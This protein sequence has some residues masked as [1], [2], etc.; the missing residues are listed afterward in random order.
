MTEYEK[1]KAWRES[2]GLTQEK[3]GELSGWSQSAIYWMEC[4]LSAPRRQADGTQG[5]PTPVDQYAWW[6]Y[7]MTCAAVDAQLRG[8]AKF[9][10]R[11]AK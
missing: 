1:A 10:W 7:K 11:P 2:H 8:G 4:G 9:E 6:R 3:L 5:K